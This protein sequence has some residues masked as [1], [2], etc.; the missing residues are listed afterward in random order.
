MK[1]LFEEPRMDVETFSV[2]DVITASNG[3]IMLTRD[4]D[5]ME[6]SPNK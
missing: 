6:L 5:E 1:K 3:D 4:S 2:E